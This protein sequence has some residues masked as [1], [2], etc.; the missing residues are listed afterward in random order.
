LTRQSPLYTYFPHPAMRT[1][2]N[3]AGVPLF[4]ATQ[5][6]RS[7]TKIAALW[8]RRLSGLR[9]RHGLKMFSL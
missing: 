6:D 7:N 4:G 8:Q 3:Q 5:A 2:R 1:R 9:N